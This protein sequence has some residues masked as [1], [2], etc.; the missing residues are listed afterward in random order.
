MNVR[1]RP[2]RR[3]VCKEQEQAKTTFSFYRASRQ[4]RRPPGFSFLEAVIDDLSFDGL[5]SGSA[6]RNA[7]TAR[8]AC[9]GA[10]KFITIQS[11]AGTHATITDFTEF[12][13]LSITPLSMR[14]IR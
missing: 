7:T 4:K 13:V 2:R 8:D 6:A 5:C 14:I 9:C 11:C 3:G 1:W 10:N 12:V